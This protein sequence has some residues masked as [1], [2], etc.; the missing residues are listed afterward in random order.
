M[1]LQLF[2]EYG[3]IVSESSVCAHILTFG[4]GKLI[5][6]NNVSKPIS[7]IAISEPIT[8]MAIYIFRI[9]TNNLID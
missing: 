6:I 8:K 9:V 4:E 2:D 1:C 3:I 7:T 5:I